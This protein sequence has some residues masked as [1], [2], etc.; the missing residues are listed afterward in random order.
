MLRKHN[1]Y[2]GLKNVSSSLLYLQSEFKIFNMRYLALFGIVLFFSSCTE[3]INDNNREGLDRELILDYIADNNLEME[4]HETGLFYAIEEVGE[5]KKVEIGSEVT[6][7]YKGYFLN[8]SIFD[9]NS[10][11][12]TSST[13]QNIKGMQLG[14]M[15]LAKGGKSKLIIPSHLAYGNDTLTSRLANEVLVFDVEVVRHW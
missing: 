3:K 7:K 8:D 12:V 6:F 9:E 2:L 4:E 15:M 10:K 1:F 13:V 11:G 14:L 5:G